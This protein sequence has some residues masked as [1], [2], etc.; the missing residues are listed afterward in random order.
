MLTLYPLSES[1]PQMC[2]ILTAPIL[3][4]AL[5]AVAPTVAARSLSGIVSDPSGD[6]VIGATVTAGTDPARTVLTAADGSFSFDSLPDTLTLTVDYT[7]DQ[8]D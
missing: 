8:G 1:I 2:K 6:P 4:A 5:A 7:T 3:L